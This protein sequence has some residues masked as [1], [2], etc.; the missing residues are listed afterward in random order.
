VAAAH[1]ELNQDESIKDEQAEPPPRLG[2]DIGDVDPPWCEMKRARR[3]MLTGPLQRLSDA[4]AKL[5]V[6]PD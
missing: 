6:E 5:L 1:V 3:E 2:R 4:P